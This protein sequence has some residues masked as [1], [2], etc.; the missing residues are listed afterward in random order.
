MMKNTN[1]N[2]FGEQL[3]LGGK[4]VVGFA[5]GFGKPGDWYYTRVIYPDDVREAKR[6]VDSKFQSVDKDVK[7]CPGLNDNDRAAWAALLASWRQLYC[8]NASGTCTDPD[9]SIFGLG[10]QMDDVERYEKS[11]YEW[12]LK[13]QATKCSLSSPVE[14]PDILKREESEK[15]EDVLDTI[16]I[17]AIAVAGAVAVVYVVPQI[18][19]LVPSRKEK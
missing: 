14:K 9:A 19:R 2:L 1:E 6:R 5:L 13:V 18:A 17:V 11:A 8:M 16:K 4:P 15:K 12:Q 7:A 3:C 10:G